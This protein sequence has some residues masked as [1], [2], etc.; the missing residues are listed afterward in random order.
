M[1]N[2]KLNIVNSLLAPDAPSL[3]DIQFSFIKYDIMQ[4]GI[5]RIV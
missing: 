2:I 1:R 5:N 3:N 4:L